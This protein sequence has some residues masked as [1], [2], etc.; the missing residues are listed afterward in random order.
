MFEFVTKRNNMKYKNF[1]SFLT[2]RYGGSEKLRGIWYHGTSTKYLS[3][4]LSQGLIVNPKEKSWDIDPDVSNVSLDRTSYGGIYVT[5]NLLTAFSSAYRT[6]KKT[7]GKS[8]IVV[9]DL[10]PKSLMADEDQFTGYFK[11]VIS[12]NGLSALWYY[13]VLKYGTTY[14][15]YTKEMN[16]AREKWA[17]EVIARIK[18]S[19]A[20]IHPK[21]IERIR[22]LLIDEGFLATLTRSAAYQDRYQW[23]RLFNRENIVPDLPEKSEAE[24]ILRTFIDKVTRIMKSS[25]VKMDSFSK[26]ARSLEPIK[27]SGSNKIVC[28]VEEQRVVLPE[29][30]YHTNLIVHYGDIPD[31]FINQYKDR[32]GEKYT[33]IKK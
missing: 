20:D 7:N 31:D 14:P 9:L 10:Q 12:I 6:A 18:Y 23:I 15:E 26:T 28:I 8:L 2:E 11:N 21:L 16:E 1:Y 24:K 3:N 32:V 30:A 17:D 13:K 5:K 4:I 25:V 27:F 29:H 33:I 22:K 19:Y